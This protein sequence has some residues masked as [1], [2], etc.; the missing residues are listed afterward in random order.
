MTSQRVKNKKC[1]IYLNALLRLY[2]IYYSTDALG[3]AIE[4]LHEIRK[5]SSGAGLLKRGKLRSELLKT[6]KNH[7]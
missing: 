4:S 6:N 2:Y 5:L 3:N 7:V 1:A